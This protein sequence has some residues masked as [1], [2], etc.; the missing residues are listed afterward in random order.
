MLSCPCTSVCAQKRGGPKACRGDGWWAESREW[1]MGV[2]PSAGRGQ[3]ARTGREEG[4]RVGEHG[5][6]ERDGKVTRTVWGA[7]RHGG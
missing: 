2:G 3:M 5:G 6:G 1:P 4:G 7:G